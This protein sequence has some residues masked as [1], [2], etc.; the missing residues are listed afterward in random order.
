MHFN[1]NLYVLN[2]NLFDLE[3]YMVSFFIR[4]LNMFVLIKFVR[5]EQIKSD[6]KYIPSIKETIFRKSSNYWSKIV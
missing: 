3:K 5:I 2:Y 1:V 4:P 6:P